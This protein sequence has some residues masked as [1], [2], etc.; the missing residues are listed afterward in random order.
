MR[1]FSKR[2]PLLF[3]R[4]K[5]AELLERAEQEKQQSLEG[6]EG[7]GF[8]GDLIPCQADG[9]KISWGTAGGHHCRLR[10]GC[11]PRLPPRRG[12]G[13]DTACAKP[14][15]A[16]ANFPVNPDVCLSQTK[17]LKCGLNQSGFDCCALFGP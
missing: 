9:Q 1:K 2:W 12:P 17:T 4:G 16:A 5:D 13:V 7:A 10:A 8:G 6:E 14:D 15:G 11:Q 3:L